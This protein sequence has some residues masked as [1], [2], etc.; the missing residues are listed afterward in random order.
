MATVTADA[1][2][3][4]GPTSTDARVASTLL[5]VGGILGVIGNALHP[6]LAGDSTTP[7]LLTAIAGRGHLWTAVHLI[8]AAAIVVLTVGAVVLVRVLDGTPGALASR[9]AAVCAVIG[10][11]IFSIQIAVFDGIGLRELADAHAAANGSAKRSIE[12]V[13]DAVATLDL[14]LLALSMVLF[15][16]V[17]FIVLGTALIRSGLFAAWIG[18]LSVLSGAVAALAGLLI[19]FNG[20]SN[21]AINFL[22]RPGAALG[23]VAILAVAL[24]LRRG[25]AAAPS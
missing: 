14:A 2:T 21:L 24:S 16:G 8:I 7:E 4:A 22:F 13:A 5:I 15:L 25:G 3:G 9:A 11:T 17:T 6:F 10:G 1:R 23:T 18:G 12:G 20:G 19:L